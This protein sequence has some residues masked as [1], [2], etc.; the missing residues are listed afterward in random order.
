MDNLLQR[1]SAL[2][3]KNLNKINNCLVL[4]CVSLQKTKNFHSDNIIEYQQ[5][6][7]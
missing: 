4:K 3:S 6:Q 7:K 2:L 5:V 1:L